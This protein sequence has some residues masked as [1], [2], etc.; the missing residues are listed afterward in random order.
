[1]DIHKTIT[2]VRH[3]NVRALQNVTSRHESNLNHGEINL[4]TEK[5]PPSKA[6]PSAELMNCG[7]L[8]GSTIAN[9]NLGYNADEAIK[10]T[11][12]QSTGPE[13]SNKVV[14]SP[15]SSEKIDNNI[16]SASPVNGIIDVLISDSAETSPPSD[17]VVILKHTELFQG[18]AQPSLT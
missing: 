9:D 12:T 16:A 7:G 1:M 3:I 14:G 11:E 18:D 17:M 10:P 8:P 2:E 13:T 5:R 15:L 4:P 6:E